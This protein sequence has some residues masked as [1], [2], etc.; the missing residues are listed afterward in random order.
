MDST[1]RF[2]VVLPLPT[3]LAVKSVF[4]GNYVFHGVWICLHYV[5]FLGCSASLLHCVASAA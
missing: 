4:C 1:C 5:G 2:L 3:V